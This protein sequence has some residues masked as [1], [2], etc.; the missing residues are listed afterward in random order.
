M[1]PTEKSAIHEEVS[2][3]PYQSRWADDFLLE[4]N[5]L[6]K[7]FPAFQAVEHIGS[8]AI[9]GMPAKPVI[10]ILA[11]VASMPI[12]HS[13]SGAILAFGYT[14]SH[15]YNESL[16]DRKWFM[17]SAGGHR[18]HHLHVVVLGSQVWLNRLLFRDRLRASPE[19]AEAYARLKADLADRFRHDREAYTV[20]KSQFVASI[21]AVD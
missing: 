9:P 12:A 4:R 17:R 8:T 16:V 1:Q 2:L 13:M 3:V 20:A 6:Q 10:D 18:T 5:R 7:R 14:T 15:A 11:G 21:L 19:L